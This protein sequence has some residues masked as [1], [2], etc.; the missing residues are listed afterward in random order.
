MRNK[1]VLW[2]VLFVAGLLVGFIPQYSTVRAL[3]RELSTKTQELASSRAKLQLCHFH[4]LAAM[5]YLEA[6]RQN[7]GSAAEQ[8]SRFF[9]EAQELASRTTEPDLKRA[10]E[11]VLNARDTITA[12]LA[13]GAPA[14]VADLQALLVKTHEL[15]GR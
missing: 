6:T 9:K 8:S 11:D 5:T 12:E 14:V 15:A 10:L 13:K 4:D 2:V 7:Y 3:R 1:L